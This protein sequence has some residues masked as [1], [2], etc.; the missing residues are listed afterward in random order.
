MEPTP[1]LRG[2][3]TPQ[4]EA[5]NSFDQLSLNHDGI[6]RACPLVISPDDLPAQPQHAPLHPL[7]QV[8]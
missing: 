1:R 3:A 7:D 6:L 2:R 8:P 4:K 5:A